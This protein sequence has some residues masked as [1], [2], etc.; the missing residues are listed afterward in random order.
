MPHEVIMP[1][2]GMAQDSGVIVSWLKNPGDPVK[3]GDALMEVETDKATM[4]VEAAHDGY[5]ADVRAGAGDSVPVGQIVAIIAETAEGAGQAPSG[6]GAERAAP[7]E[8]PA[9]AGAEAVPEGH[10]VIMPALGMAQDSGIVVA[11]HKEAGEAVAEGDALLE[12]ETDKATMEVEADRAGYLAAILA[13]A[14][15]DV[16]VGQVIAVISAE[17]PG[18]PIR[19]AM[20]AAPQGG[21]TAPGPEPAARAEPTPQTEPAPGPDPAAAALPTPRPAAAPKPAGRVL[22]SPKARRL[23]AEEGLDLA[24]LVAAGHQPPFHVADLETLRALP[25][26]AAAQAAAGA[27]PVG[28]GEV[29][30]VSAEVDATGFDAFRAWLQEEGTAPS[31]PRLLAAFAA[32]A[33]RAARTDEAPLTVAA[34]TLGTTTAWDDPDRAP[35]SADLPESEARPRLVLRDLTGTALTGIKPAAAPV[36]VVTITRRGDTLALHLAHEATLPDEAAL[37]L[38]SGLADRLQEPLRHLL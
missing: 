23:A 4:E 1:A 36:P 31:S 30:V 32:G 5:L 38:L 25:K 6:N 15:D 12:V 35:V 10:E 21:A 34:G 27:G 18:A 33:L 24:D 2:L 28:V 19:R 22:A 16:P 14:G 9:Q 20:A 37:T 13:E 3:T 11:W 17:A 7:D 8:T 29:G 26:P